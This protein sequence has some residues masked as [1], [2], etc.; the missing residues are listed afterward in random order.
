MG[1]ACSTD[2]EYKKCVYNFTVHRWENNIKMNLKQ[3]GGQIVGWI[4]L[5]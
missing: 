3:I 4:K 5:A 2:G 1:G